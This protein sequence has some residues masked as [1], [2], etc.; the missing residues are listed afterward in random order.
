MNT[1]FGSRLI[2]SRP[3]GSRRTHNPEKS[4]KA[5]GTFR[6]FTNAQTPEKMRSPR[7]TCLWLALALTMV[8]AQ[9][10]LFSGLT[11]NAQAQVQTAPAL[12]TPENLGNPFLA[13][14]QIPARNV[15][16]MQL[17]D[18]Q[19]FL[20]HGDSTKN[21]G[22][23]PI[24]VFQP[25]TGTFVNEYRTSSEQVDMF[26][27]VDGTLT[28]LDHDPLGTA[29]SRLYRRQSPGVWTRNDGIETQAHLYDIAKRGNTLFVAGG[30][31][32]QPEGQ[33]F[34][35]Y[36]SKDN[37]TTWK[38]VLQAGN[39][40]N[41]QNNLS[42]T[43][44]LL[45]LKGA[46]YGV[47]PWIARGSAANRW[48]FKLNTGTGKFDYLP[49]PGAVLSPGFSTNLYLRYKRP[50]S[51]PD[52]GALTL[53]VQNVNDHQWVPVQLLHLREF[54]AGGVS[55]I[56]LPDG[57]LAYDLMARGDLV[58]VCAWNGAARQNLVYALNARDL[59][60]A[61]VEVLRFGAPTFAR[62]FEESEGTFYF[63][64]GCNEGENNPATGEI[65][66]V[67]TKP[68]IVEPTATPA[69]EPTATPA[70]TA[71]PVPTSAPT[72][73][74]T[75]MP[76]PAPTSEPE[77]QG[78]APGL[79]T[80]FYPNKDLTGAP[81]LQRIDG[82]ITLSSSNP[83]LGS[84]APNTPTTTLT[85]TWGVCWEGQLEAPITGN[86][87]LILHTNNGVRLWFNDRILL[88]DWNSS[89][90]SQ[91]SASIEV[92][93]G[94]RYGIRIEYA[95]N[96]GSPLFQLHWAWNGTTGLVPREYLWHHSEDSY[97]LAAPQNVT[98]RV[99]VL[100]NGN[101]Q[102]TVGWTDALS[103]GHSGYKIEQLVSGKWK[104]LIRGTSP[105]QREFVLAANS[106]VKPVLR[107]RAYKINVANGP[108]AN[109]L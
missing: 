49:T 72:P 68:V 3:I 91:K 9:V 20:G 25:Q 85:N 1:L 43:Y 16:D 84:L 106:T 54:A 56:N 24:W 15:W 96:A 66:R 100:P 32:P 59:T 44:T 27:V 4:L 63:G 105:T 103:Y 34:D 47:R 17:F 79:E 109:S 55:Q 69:P 60:A 57:A 99:Q 36:A 93:Q 13:K 88:E 67:N 2:G 5:Q 95:Q 37:G 31:W 35:I 22:P 98:P 12:S 23:T 71:T 8:A 101:S 7:V 39:P 86:I 11:G 52:G 50:L 10:P 87:R 107:I 6:L 18:G 62:S 89:T 77:S 33:N 81:L 73:M 80:T 94:Q 40:S 42:R 92:Q 76:T 82:P 41:A 70:P 53:L 26:T 29:P 21:S 102:W 65:W 78:L 38:G 28:T 104:Q 64:L 61:P 58:Y 51:L 97:F 14:T 46:L 90:L 83:A 108:F 75:T 45:P 30:N 74:P 48:L 19:I